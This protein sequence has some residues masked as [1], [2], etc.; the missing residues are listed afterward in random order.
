MEERGVNMTIHEYGT[1][2]E[3][4]VV[5]IHPSVVRWDYFEYVIP[6]LQEDCRLLVPA[7]PGYDEEHR[8]E[9]FTSIEDIADRLAK[10]LKAHR[11]QT[12]DLLY[13]CSMGGA[14]ALRMLADG[15][16]AVRNTVC[17]GGITPYQLPWLVTRLIAA[18]DFAMISLGK[19]G[20]LRLLEKAFSTEEYGKEDLLYVSEVLRSMSYK[21]IWRTFDSC[22]NY[23]MPP[24]GPQVRGRFQYWYGEKEAKD[25]AWDIRYIEKH[26]PNAEFVR[27]EN[28]GHASMA[29]L[30]PQEM[31]ERLRLCLDAAAPPR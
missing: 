12:V 16:V 5:L 17:D 3:R 22:N 24:L 6:L 25:R 11:I 1:G 4:V 15:Q 7:L 23:A 19:L 2:S 9:D 18:R 13:G 21:T 26:V 27:L 31:A 28:R 20:G 8:D 30:Y 10:W 14:I 29:S